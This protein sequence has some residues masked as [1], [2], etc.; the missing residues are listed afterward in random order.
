MFVPIK[1]KDLVTMGNIL[2]GVGSMIA[3]I[4]GSLE[5]ACYLML[6]AWI[7]D[8]LDGTVARL[9]GGGNKFGEVFDNLADLVS[10]SLAP[11][12]ILYLAYHTPAG[13]GGAGWPL[14]AAGM[15]AALPTVFGCVRFT[16]NNVKPF[17]MHEWHL[18]LPR[19]MY[20]LFIATLFA[21]HVFRGPWISDPL[22]N[23]MLY[24][25]AAVLILAATGLTLTLRPYH[26]RPRRSS[27]SLVYFF[28][29][30]FLIT[31]PL[32][33]LIGIVLGDHRLFFDVLLVNFSLY[34]W[35]Q[36]LI[37]P[38]SKR[39]QVKAHAQKLILQWREKMG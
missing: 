22:A 14:W 16:R 15:L 21:S 2:G 23:K 1:I 24:G 26:S 7:F 9:T 34:V 3:C 35:C 5:W 19:P 27:R 37:I 13:L 38:A 28:V 39:R 12:F 32:G 33:F 17:I 4:E 30:W 36:H 31:S 10:Y 25:I 6:I 29:A 18:G 8:M 20:A 11:S